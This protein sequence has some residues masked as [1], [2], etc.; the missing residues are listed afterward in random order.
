MSAAAFALVALG[1]RTPV[2]L[3]TGLATIRYR[4]ALRH[5]CILEGVEAPTSKHP[6]GRITIRYVSDDVITIV[7]PGYCR[8]EFV[9]IGAAP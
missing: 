6:R 9:E 5:A 7:S 3:G 1:S 4:D 2:H 8:L